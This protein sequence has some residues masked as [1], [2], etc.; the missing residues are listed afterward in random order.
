[1]WNYTLSKN[2]WFIACNENYSWTSN[3]DGRNIVIQWN[4]SGLNKKRWKLRLRIMN[5]ICFS[6]DNDISVC[7]CI[8][9]NFFSNMQNTRC[10]QLGIINQMKIRINIIHKIHYLNCLQISFLVLY[11]KVLAS[12]QNWFVKSLDR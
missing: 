8:C 7:Y 12:M 11:K 1:M 5:K 9:C 4:M 10:G 6:W 2:I 3:L